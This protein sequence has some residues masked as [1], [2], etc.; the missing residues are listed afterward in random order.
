MLS[1]C[2]QNE[3]LE[4]I[5]SLS[6]KEFASII[7]PNE[8]VTAPEKITNLLNL[9]QLMYGPVGNNPCYKSDIVLREDALPNRILHS[10]TK[11]DSSICIE[12]SVTFQD[13]RVVPM[14]DIMEDVS[15]TST[16]SCI[17]QQAICWR[18]KICDLYYKI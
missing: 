6:N 13:F 2:A 15:H 5:P 9:P 16:V 8:S 12:D 1:L 3:E 17:E 7:T 4:V 18:V 10:T 14:L 11:D